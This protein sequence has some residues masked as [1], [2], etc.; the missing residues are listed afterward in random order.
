MRAT[1]FATAL[2]LF[3][4][5]Y[6]PPAIAQAADYDGVLVFGYDAGGDELYRVSFVSGESSPVNAN[7]G[8]ALSAG[9]LLYNT[10]T[11]LWQTQITAGLKYK[12]INATN[13][14]ATWTAFP[15]EVIEFLNTDMFRFGAGVTYQMNPKLRTG[16]VL[17]GHDA[18]FDNALGYIF[19]IG[20]RNG[21]RQRFS[22]DF[23]YTAI[24]YSGEID[25]AGGKQRIT[26]VGGGSLGFYIATT[27]L[28]P[29]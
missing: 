8:F 27:F 13:G 23:R 14:D 26:N 1:R 11:L 5:L 17:S 10:D 20:F 15:L 2:V 19:Q 9:A 6:F 21:R 22:V 3:A 4:S 28:F 24:A 25:V 12:P 16:G 7:Q 29:D 18:D